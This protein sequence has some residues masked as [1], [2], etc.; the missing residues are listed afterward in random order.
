MKII[1]KSPKSKI[2]MTKFKCQNK[3]KIQIASDKKQIFLFVI[4]VLYFFCH[5]CFVIWILPLYAQESKEPV[6]ESVIKETATKEPVKQPVTINGDNVEYS[7]DSKE[8]SASGNVSIIYKDTTLTCK[9]IKVNTETKEGQAIGDVRLEDSKGVIEGE[10]IAYN[11]QNKTGVITDARFRADPYF[12]RAEKLDKVS[13]AEFIGYRSY[14]T[15]C[16]Y[17]NPH[18]RLKSKKVDFFPGDKVKIKDVT[19]NFGQTKPVPVFYLPG[20]THSLKDPFM[21][22]QVV[23][24]KTKDWGQYLLTATRYDVTDHIKGRIYLDYRN[25]LGVAEGF[26]TNYGFPNQTGDFKLYYTQERD[27]SK[28]L[29][30]D[31]NFPKVFERYMVRWR[32]KWEIGEQTNLISQYYKLVDSR[33]ALLGSDNNFLKD[34]FPREFDKETTPLSYIQFHHS[35]MFGGL[36][37]LYQK[38]VNRWYTELEKLPE[39]SYSMPSIQLGSTPF[40]FENNSSLSNYIYKQAVPSSSVN[41]TRMGRF[42]TYNKLSI[43]VRVLFFNLSP[44]VATRQTYYNADINGASIA[45]RT[46]FYTGADLTTKF[47]R[48]FNVKTNFLGMDVNDLRHIITPTVAYAYTR[49][50]TIPSTKL[51][52]IDG[53]DSIGY[54]N[55]VTIGLQNKLQTKRNKVTVDLLDFRI[56]TGYTLYSVDTASN[57]KKHGQLS[58]FKLNL[59]FLPYSWLK[60]S[61]DATYSH[62]EKY[63]TQAN[64]DLNFSFGTDRSLSIG[65]RYA[66]KYNKEMT[67]SA[68]WRFTPKWRIEVYER[69]QFSKATPTNGGLREQRYTI[70]RD[71]HCWETELNFDET[72]GKGATIWWVFRLKAFPELEFDYNRSY[73]APKPGSQANN[74]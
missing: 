21:K 73:N 9:E 31:V 14:I 19:F 54:N 67:L 43:P 13:E 26:I 51:K 68:N 50:P 44:F 60:L 66:R 71:L 57:T 69:V 37:I 22:T 49:Q 1:K 6:K 23:G 38:R 16:S 34:Y 11:F 7:A 40:F 35:F 72:R 18:W 10:K 52:Q 4:C 2:L 62:K 5:L 30:E 33:R 36:D 64:S 15:T 17:D 55:S 47:Y 53:I 27:K 28:R 56:D 3:S 61:N 48:I 29:P 46:V 74:I 45:P 65:H 58:D 59:E 63:F 25:L 8:V 20:Y 24:G 39:A 32:H 70:A 42:D 41:D 12:G